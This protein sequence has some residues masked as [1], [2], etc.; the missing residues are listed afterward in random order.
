M[1]TNKG[2][3]LLEL[4]I[5][6]TIMAIIVAIAIPNYT[7]YVVR[8]QRVEARNALQAVAQQIDQNYRVT[9]D[10][11]KLANGDTLSNA[12]ISSWGFANI[13]SN[14]NKRYEI[15]FVPNT[16]TPTGYTLQAQ[17]VGKQAQRD[18]DCAYFFYN[19]SGTKMASKTVTPPSGG[20]DETS[21]GCWSK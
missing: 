11:S 5:V 3:T 8:A 20:R 14:A 17:A 4:L 2:F 7:R 12:T 21:L 16:V 9:R 19:Q 1:K 13:P 10:Y 15:S 18:K 6:I